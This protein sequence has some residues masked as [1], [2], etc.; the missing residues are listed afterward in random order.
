MVLITLTTIGFGEVHPLSPQGRVFTI[1]L[2]VGGLGLAT[3]TVTKLTRYV[4]DGE[5][6]DYIR[7][8]RRMRQMEQ[9]KDHIIVIGYGRLGREV[10]EELS[11]RGR[12]VLAIDRDE[13]VLENQGHLSAYLV[14]DGSSDEL[15]RQAAINRARGMAVAT[16]SDATNIFVTLSARQMNE[17]LHILTRVNE[18]GSSPKA[19]R[20]GANDVINPYGIG[21]ARMAQGLLNPNAALVVD[22]AV[23]RAHAEFEIEDIVIGESPGYNGQL[24]DLK[25]PQLHKVLVVAVR[26][27]DGAL[28]TATDRTT[29]LNPGDIAIVVGQPGDIEELS[30]AARGERLPHKS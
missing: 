20:A 2:I 28:V 8:R 13:A 18:I 29:E 3:Y 30:R 27:P 15:L 22:R 12:Q 7:T 21:G 5:L 14:G 17:R 24:S 4:V 19:R 1:G 9:L 16:G 10:S 25:I 11:H 6:S 23:G 26:K